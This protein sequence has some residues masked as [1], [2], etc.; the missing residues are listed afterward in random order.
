[1]LMAT[2]FFIPETLLEQTV[3][4]ET[5]LVETMPPGGLSRDFDFSSTLG[6]KHPSYRFTRETEYSCKMLGSKEDTD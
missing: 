1:M 2:S 6:R 3:D 4:N 5:M